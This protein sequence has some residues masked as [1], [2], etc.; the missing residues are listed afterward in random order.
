MTDVSTLQ[1]IDPCPCIAPTG[2]TCSVPCLNDKHVRS[3]VCHGTGQVVRFPALW[4]ECPCIKGPLYCSRCASSSW[5]A[6]NGC[7]QCK[8]FNL[9]FAPT[10][11]AA[12]T[13]V[14]TCHIALDKLADGWKCRMVF[15]TPDG[16]YGQ[17]VDGYGD[18]LL[19]AVM[20]TLAMLDK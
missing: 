9:V 3:C 19:E 7:D 2:V 14:P 20:A 11:E 4:Q 6:S 12:L 8:N 16:N 1:A 10:L 13:A 18:T 5:H 15:V 17:D